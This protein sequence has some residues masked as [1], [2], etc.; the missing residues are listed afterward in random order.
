VPAL[1]GRARARE[2]DRVAQALRLQVRTRC[3][4]ERARDPFAPVL[5]MDDEAHERSRFSE[6]AAIRGVEA[7]RVLVAIEARGVQP[8]DDRAVTVREDARPPARLHA[9]ELRRA[10]RVARGE[11]GV[12]GVAGR[13]IELVRTAGPVFVVRKTRAIEEREKVAERLRAQCAD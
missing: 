13:V 2:A 10:M 5:G 8:A 11:R 7:T 3:L 9:G 4:E 1:R 12:P 6:I